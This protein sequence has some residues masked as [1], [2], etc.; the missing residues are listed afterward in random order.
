MAA[1]QM[2]WRKEDALKLSRSVQK[3]NSSI[4]KLSNKHPELADAGLFP[5]KLDISQIKERGLSRRD[6]NR[7]LKRIDRWFNPKN[8]EIIMRHG[9]RMTRYEYN[10]ARYD[11]MS[12]QSRSKQKSNL[13]GRSIRQQQKIKPSD[14]FNVEKKLTDLQSRIHSDALSEFTPE[15]ALDAWKMFTQTAFIKSGEYYYQKG[16]D[17]YYKN[18]EKAVRENFPADYADQIME[19]LSS[20]GIDGY[21]LYTM[22]GEYPPL[23]IDY[24]YGPEEVEAKIEQLIDMI[25]YVYNKLFK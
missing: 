1:K 10:E 9:I 19:L 17:L 2:R 3:F 20:L 16:F 14:Q 21:K 8:R 25:P 5:Q 15:D 22:V 7:L 11:A 18:Y 6:Y 24:L 23:D 12:I 13:A 4:T